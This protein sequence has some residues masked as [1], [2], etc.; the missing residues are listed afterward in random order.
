[1]SSGHSD[2]RDSILGD[3]AQRLVMESLKR[4][5]TCARC[6]ALYSEIGNLGTWHCTGFHPL[7]A[8][9]LT[10]D[11]RV[12]CCRKLP[13]QGGCV[14]ADHTDRYEFDVEPQSIHESVIELV[15][16]MQNANW[17]KTQRAASGWAVRRFDVAAYQLALKPHS[18]LSIFNNVGS[19]TSTTPL[20]FTQ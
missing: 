5:R 7:A 18:S 8:W 4:L 2:V 6:G 15:L 12:S 17:V 9:P 10:P 14:A 3:T 20:W 11:G 1:M 19:K 13:S 16:K